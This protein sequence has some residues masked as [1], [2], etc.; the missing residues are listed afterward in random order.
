MRRWIVTVLVAASACGGELS[1]SADASSD[2]PSHGDGAPAEAAAM[3]APAPVC[4]SAGPAEYAGAPLPAQT[5]TFTITWNVIPQAA[6]ID[7]AVVLGQSVPANPP[8]SAF[9]TLVLFTAT[10]VLQARNGVNPTA[11]AVIPYAAGVTY[12][13][14]AVVD[15]PRHRYSVYVTPPGGAEVRLAQDFQF[16]ETQHAVTGLDGWGVKA[17]EGTLEACLL[18]VEGAS[19][20]ATSC[21][22]RG[23]TCGHPDNGCG[24]PL[25]CGTCAGAGLSVHDGAYGTTVEGNTI[26]DNV[27]PAVQVG[28]EVWWGGQGCLGTYEAL[29]PD[30][31][32]A[33]RGVGV[34]ATTVTDNVVYG[35][36]AGND[37]TGQILI[38]GNAA[39]TT[40]S[41][42]TTAH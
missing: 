25:D 17:A 29:D 19:C 26:H 37:S 35:N 36:G 39:N 20:V 22:A 23:W 34:D 6:D 21:D 14:R 24:T 38:G 27:G 4:L 33:S 1:S 40:L 18:G 10:G 42:N 16:R 11:D 9:A 8:W 31:H 13:I 41:G 5:G 28:V 2:A 15:V 12:R 32:G 30:L 7:A 3:D